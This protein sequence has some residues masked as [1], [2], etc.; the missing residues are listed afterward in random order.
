MNL[1]WVSWIGP[2]PHLAPKKRYDEVLT[3]PHPLCTSE[4]DLSGGRIRLKW[5]H[6]SGFLSSMTAVLIKRGNSDIEDTQKEND[7]KRHGEEGSHLQAKERGLKQIHPHSPRKKPIRRHLNF[8]LLSLRTL[9][10]YISF[11]EVSHPVCGTVCSRP[12]KLTQK[13]WGL[14]ILILTNHLCTYPRENFARN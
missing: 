10:Q 12:G 9:K 4:C 5:G 13:L 11:C 7:M 8:R 14:F 3:D 1:L 6:E 2:L